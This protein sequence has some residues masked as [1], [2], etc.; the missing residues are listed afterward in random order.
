MQTDVVETPEISIINKS[1]INMIY[2]KYPDVTF[3]CS[4]IDSNSCLR[5]K[6]ICTINNTQYEGFGEEK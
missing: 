1:P 6:V 5:F 2:E 3:E 4:S